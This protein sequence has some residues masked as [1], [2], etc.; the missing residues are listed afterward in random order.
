[1]YKMAYK[2]STYSLLCLIYTQVAN[3]FE[4]P[5]VTI[6][7]ANSEKCRCGHLMN[8]GTP[9]LACQKSI[10]LV[11]YNYLCTLSDIRPV[12]CFKSAAQQY[13]ALQFN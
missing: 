4:E 11:Y 10:L 8:T 13:F 3:K 2:V 5:V 9:W 6:Y 12:A 7:I 1:M